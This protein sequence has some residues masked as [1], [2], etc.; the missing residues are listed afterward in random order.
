MPM[1]SGAEDSLS[2]E[3]GK[4]AQIDAISRD[5]VVEPRLSALSP[6]TCFAEKRIPSEKSADRLMSAG[7]ALLRSNRIEHFEQTRSLRSHQCA[8]QTTAQWG[9]SVARW[10][11]WN[12][13]RYAACTVHEKKGAAE[14]FGKGA[15]SWQGQ[16]S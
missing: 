14:N 16:E 1:A 12:T 7:C 6:L 9:V 2:S 5:Y 11:S 4:K 15:V 8:L 13:L 3:L 10:S